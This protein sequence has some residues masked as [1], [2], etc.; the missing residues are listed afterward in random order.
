MSDSVS[1]GWRR[2]AQLRGRGAKAAGRKKAEREMRPLNG[3]ARN[4]DIAAREGGSVCARSTAV[5]ARGKA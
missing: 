1:A 4:R 3:G 2:L 5:T